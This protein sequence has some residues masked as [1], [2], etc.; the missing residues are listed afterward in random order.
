M[1][2][3]MI[4]ITL[5]HI[6]DILF[7]GEALELS[8]LGISVNMPIDQAECFRDGSGR[9]IRFDLE[10]NLQPYK[11]KDHISGQG[12]INSVRRV[13]QNHCSVS[14]RFADLAQGGYHQIAHHLASEQPEAQAEQL[15]G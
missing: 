8:P 2:I 4:Q 7:E 10:L 12:I 15:V 14:I 3:S 6:D 1:D 11:S 5:K 9:F 13:S